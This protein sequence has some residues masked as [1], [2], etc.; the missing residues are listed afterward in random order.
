MGIGSTSPKPVRPDGTTFTFTPADISQLAAGGTGIPLI[1]P[2]FPGG[3]K[4][5]FACLIYIAN[6]KV[7][8]PYIYFKNIS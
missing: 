5:N 6:N 2:G 3:K 4:Y 1:F 7:L 8:T